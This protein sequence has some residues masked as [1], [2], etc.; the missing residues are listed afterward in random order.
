[1]TGNE[2][3]GLAG[4]FG[5]AVAADASHYN[6]DGI[7]EGH[8]V[9]TTD[10]NRLDT[11][12]GA[13]NDTD[14]LSLVDKRAG[15]ASLGRRIIMLAA[16]P[17]FGAADGR[18]IHQQTNVSGQS[19]TPGMGYAVGIEDKNVRLLPEFADSG[20]NGRCF[21]ETQ[22]SRHV[23][24]T[25]LPPGQGLF[26]HAGLLHIVENHATKASAAISTERKIGPGYEADRRWQGL[27]A[28]PLGEASLKANSRPWRYG[29]TV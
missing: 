19:H 7:I 23:R 24:K 9:A 17:T 13:K 10:E 25:G 12:A 21:P 29:P 11:R 16:K 22:Q 26:N 2:D 18:A 3:V 14:N 4:G 15:S 5:Q 8:P 1:M 28:N 20:Q 6:P 27:M